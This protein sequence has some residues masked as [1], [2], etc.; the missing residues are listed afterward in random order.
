MPVSQEYEQG[1]N[2]LL[3]ELKDTTL[4]PSIWNLEV[5]GLYFHKGGGTV[6]ANNF[7]FEVL[8]DLE[9]EYK[10]LIEGQMKVPL[11]KSFELLEAFESREIIKIDKEL[12][13]RN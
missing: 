1:I 10:I 7:T 2:A 8:E 5:G 6:F 12:Y 3:K 13:G 4:Q 11:E 9:D